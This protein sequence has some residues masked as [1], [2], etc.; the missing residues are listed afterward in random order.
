MGT[1]IAIAPDILSATAR[2]TVP[3][4]LV[5]IAE[6][7]SERAGLVNI[8]LDGLMSVGALT[9]FLIGYFS[10]NPWLGLLAGALAGVV[11]NLIFAFCTVK[12]CVDQVVC[13]MAINILAP[14]IATFA[15]KVSFG[16]SSSLVQGVKM[17]TVSIPVLCDIP[18]IGPAFF[19]QTPL[20]YVAYLLVPISAVFFREF[21][22]GLSYR[23]VGENPQAAE[24]LGI[25]VIGI[26]VIACVICGAL[27]GLGG[28]FLTLC[29]TSTYAEGI[30][31]GRGFIALSAVIFGRWTSSGVLGACLL[32]GF[33]DALQIVLQI[34]MPAAPYQFFQMIPYVMT[35]AA[36]IVFGSKRNGP[37]ANGQPYYRGQ[38]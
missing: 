28:S 8:G 34:N 17:A 24:T 7:F 15:Y 6:L 20:A 10:G 33:C 11:C 30:V 16:D 2:M 37:K 14:A 27:A 3:L 12:L 18:V 9:G 4:L 31:A 29:Y 36:L 19:C 38:R 21:R 32:F 1:I 26:K 35:L 25:N 5:A 23:A 13:G 22:A